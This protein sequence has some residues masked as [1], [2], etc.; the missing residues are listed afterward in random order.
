M[1]PTAGGTQ[2]LSP[3][4]RAP[5]QGSPQPS[6]RMPA[7]RAGTVHPLQSQWRGST[8]QAEGPP[9]QSVG[10]NST[11]LD[12]V[13]W[14][15]KHNVDMVGNVLVLGHESR[16]HDP[17]QRNAGGSPEPK[18][19]LALD[20][21]T[22]SPADARYAEMLGKQAA[23]NMLHNT[24]RRYD[25]HGTPAAQ[26]IQDVC[27][28]LG[29][30][31][32]RMTAGA[33][34]DIVR[35][36][37]EMVHAQESKDLGPSRAPREAKRMPMECLTH[38]GYAIRDMRHDARP[39]HRQFL[40]ELGYETMDRTMQHKLRPDETKD[41]LRQVEA[42][43]RQAGLEGLGK[44]VK[45][46]RHDIPA[47]ADGYETRLHDNIYGRAMESVLI[48]ELVRDPPAN[49]KQGMGALAL[50]LD[51]A[52]KALPRQAQQDVALQVQGM[53]R[54]ERRGWQT[55]SPELEAFFNAR[56]E[57]ALGALK[58]L[59]RAPMDNGFD[60]IAIP[61]VSVKMSLCMQAHGAAP[62]MGKANRNY[63]NVVGPAAARLTE[64]AAN[65]NRMA[66]KSGITMH[67]QPDI[68]RGRESAM[69]PG[70]RNRPNLEQASPEL[71][72]ALEHGVSFV[73]GVS[74]STN[75]VMH[76]VGDILDQGGKVDPKDA[77][78]GTMMFLNYDGGHSM[79]EA[80][81][82]GNQ[83]DRSLDLKMDMPGGDPRNFVADYDRF[84][85]SFP[86]AKGRDQLRAAA[87]MAWD[88]T[89]DHFGRHSHF[90]PENRPPIA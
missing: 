73:S 4:A 41:W 32:T 56:P 46:L 64:G 65:A 29:D 74:G 43:C 78:L 20:S 2:S 25:L 54:H 88:K 35:D 82:V 71:H 90:S 48:A 19:K 49:V 42:D 17:R 12:M 39:E 72:T 61:Y 75:I 89:L 47:S 81:W 36:V 15:T 38:L 86:Q 69:H 9:S 13:K 50:H 84:I 45:R 85:E 60:C 31:R 8:S 1:P 10:C 79:H 40:K 59:L 3:P 18:I 30:P 24:T 68:V 37:G 28:W 62:W 26:F 83:L 22:L 6:A 5:A 66:P 7:P 33:L 76:M 14:D 67:H 44:L 11:V 21:G 34:G 58:R 63:A 57:H 77:L 51:L 23:V 70:D 80:M 27:D 87:D 53:M 52:L 55:K 16:A